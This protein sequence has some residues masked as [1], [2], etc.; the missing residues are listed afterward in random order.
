MNRIRTT[1]VG[2][3][4]LCP[5]CGDVHEVPVVGTQHANWR[6]NRS[7][8]RPTIE[9][10]IDVKSGHYASGWKPGDECWCNKDYQFSCYRCH[11]VREDHVLRG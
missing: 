11:S 5:G 6:W 7:L 3:S 1:E 8:V 4:F 2:L 10:S 9:P